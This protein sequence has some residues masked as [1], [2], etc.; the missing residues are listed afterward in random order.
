VD[1]SGPDGKDP[2]TL[3]ADYCLVCIGRKP[4]TEGLR[5]E[6]A[7]I[8][9]DE[10]GR[11]IVD[12]Y[13]RTDSPHIFAIGDVIRGAMLAH[14]AEEE[15]VF[16][17][18]VLAGQKPHIHY[19]LIPNV[20]YTWPELAS[21]GATED[22]LKERGIAYK[23]GKFPYKALGRARASMDL[24]GMVKI[25]ADEK[26]DRLLGVHIVGARAA[27]LIMEGV[28]LM[29]FGASAEDMARICH[30]HPTY[31]EAVREAALQATAN[32]AIHS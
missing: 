6:A 12:E 10:R 1:F 25:M 23:V 19:E 3:K 20:V 13:L 11:I 21:V 29:E 30:P 16:V 14:K 26:T 2:E 15:G 4:Y 22:Q 27:D 18:E 28:A 7:G 31:S 32:R 8:R 5:P 24:D 17:A 9:L